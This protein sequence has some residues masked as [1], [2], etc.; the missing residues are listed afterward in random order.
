MAKRKTISTSVEHK[1]PELLVPRQEAER[2]IQEQLD[3]LSTITADLDTVGSESDFDRVS[4]SY[5]T[6]RSF[7]RELLRRI[8]D[9][10]EI[11]EQFEG[12]GPIVVVGGRET[13]GDQIRSRRDDIRFDR[14]RLV[15]VKERLLL[16]PEAES[17]RKLTEDRSEAVLEKIEI[18]LTRFHQI[19][20]QLRRRHDNRPTLDIEDEYDVQDLLHALLRLFFDDIREEEWTPSYAGGAS[21]VDFL[22]KLEKTLIEVKKAR[23]SLTAKA[24]GDQLII[25]IALYQAHPDCESLICF[26]Y[27]PDG[28][29]RNATGLENDLS[30]RHGNLLVK[31]YV[32]PR[33]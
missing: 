16:I 11:A 9:T 21:R 17:M 29:V 1:L 12:R 6:W 13:L 2:L 25:D 15:S 26:V 4:D 24:I 18:I 5:W 27:D 31:V 14:R 32:M 28:Y 33:G 22:L 20:R 19:A 7:V 10:E 8:F 30:K 23:K 3:K